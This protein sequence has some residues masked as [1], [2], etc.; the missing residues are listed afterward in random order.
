[1]SEEISTKIFDGFAPYVKHIDKVDLFGLGEPMLD[2]HLF[3]RI[4]YAKSLGYRNL[5]ISTNAQMLTGSKQVELLESR[6]ETVIFRLMESKRKHTSDSS[7][8]DL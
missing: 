6:I 5:A 1:M 2:P 7:E 8:V 4:R 3:K